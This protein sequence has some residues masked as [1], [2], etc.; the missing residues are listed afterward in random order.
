MAVGTTDPWSLVPDQPYVDPSELA[1]AIVAQVQ[2]GDLDFRTRLLIRDSLNALRDYWG[3]RR[4]T[5][6][7][8]A[9][10]VQPELESIW[11]E[12]L[13]RVG[14]PFLRDQCMEPTRPEHIR[15][16]LRD[17]G[18]RLQRPARLALGGS[19]ALILQGYLLRRTQALDVV[20]ELPSEIRALGPRLKELEQRYRLQLG[21]FQSHYLPSGWEQRVHALEPF[22]LLNV[23][24]VDVYD[25]FLSKLCRSREKDQDDLRVVAPQLDKE[26]LVRRLK[27]T[28]TGL[29]SQPDLRQ[30][31]E[32]NWYS[33]YGEALPS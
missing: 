31:A 2:R 7:L 19:G 13:G 10:P 23:Y 33:L 6:W 30:K 32:R 5:A 18:S 26:T 4:L 27:E 9:T 29:L 1:D 25:V 14:F 20:D 16:L 24:A 8:A 12:D 21:Y 17:L 3:Q 22:G 15:Q 28:A 11:R